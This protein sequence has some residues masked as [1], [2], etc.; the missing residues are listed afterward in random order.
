MYLLICRG[1]V[2]NVREGS[3]DTQGVEGKISKEFLDIL[4]KCDYTTFYK[5]L[6]LNHLSYRHEKISCIFGFYDKFPKRQSQL[7]SFYR[8]VILANNLYSN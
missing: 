4:G 6:I 8:R 3:R 5:M 2:E 7:S 1:K